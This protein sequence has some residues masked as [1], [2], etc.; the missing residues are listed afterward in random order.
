MIPGSWPASG[1]SVYGVYTSRGT[2][3][4]GDGERTGDADI[5]NCADD[6]IGSGSSGSR[7]GSIQ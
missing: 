6:D 4:R 2:S 7:L 1:S 5:G 3:V